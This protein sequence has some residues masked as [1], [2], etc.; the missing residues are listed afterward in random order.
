LSGLID[1]SFFHPQN[2]KI[3]IPLLTLVL[4]NN[5][6]SD[7]GAGGVIALAIMMGMQMVEKG[8]RKKILKLLESKSFTIMEISK[9]LQMDYKTVWQH[10]KILE[11]KKLISIKQE[12]HKPGKPIT[13]S[14]NKEYAES[15][16]KEFESLKI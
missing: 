10:V 15:K 9:I 12:Q 16:A 8:T 4:M 14:L 11:S 13:V 5:P 7:G 1:L 2:H 6:V 3:Y